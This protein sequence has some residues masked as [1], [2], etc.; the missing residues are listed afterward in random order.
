MAY[1][2]EKLN[3]EEDRAKK[4]LD[5]SSFDRLISASVKVLVV[6]F[7]DQLLA[8]GPGLIKQNEVPRESNVWLLE[9]FRPSNAVWSCEQ[10][11]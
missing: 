4:Y 6:Q 8:E 9:V 5:E 10:D 2:F 1:A 3:E 11:G 7:Q